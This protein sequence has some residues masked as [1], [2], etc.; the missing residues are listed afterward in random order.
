MDGNKKRRVGILEADGDEEATL[1]AAAVEVVDGNL[2]IWMRAR[3]CNSR[4]TQAAG[5]I[6][7]CMCGYLH[8]SVEFFS[9]M[10]THDDSDDPDLA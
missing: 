9:R 8:I 10:R 7:T 6:G 3:L 1:P 5:A 4:R 2:R